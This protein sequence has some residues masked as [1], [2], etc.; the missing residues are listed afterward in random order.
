MKKLKVFLVAAIIITTIAAAFAGCGG[1]IKD[2]GGG[3]LIKVRVN[4]VMRSMFYTPMYVAINEG[5]FK[6]EGL[7]IELTIGNGADKTMQQ[8]LSNNADIGFCGSEQVIYTYNQGREDYPILFAQLTKKDGS[9]IVARTPDPDFTWEKLKGKTVLGGRPAGMPEMS[10]E[11]V[12]RNH[13]LTISYNDEQ[14][15][16]DVNIITNVAFA[17]TPAAFKGGIGDYG[18]LFE[19]YPTILQNE[20]AAYIVASVGEEAGE[21]PYTCYFAT[22]SYIEKN[23]EIIQKFTNAL[24]KAV[25]WVDTH[26]AEQAA[27]STKS[28]FPGVDEKQIAAVIQRFKD[29]D[30]WTKDLILTKEA[31]SRI[32]N[33]IQSYKADL[34]PKR[35]PYDKIVTT[36]F[37]EEAVKNIK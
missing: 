10:L 14:P 22:K 26:T 3:N 13:G 7:D 11:Y 4:E 1:S 28:F 19:P 31:L 33:I 35:P 9:F 12:I 37:A 21:I 6:E 27:A 36:K 32:C 8:V 15:Q 18:A 16:K 17:S 20:G 5:F 24:Y 29:L 30:T 25:R 2:N 34:M 23:P